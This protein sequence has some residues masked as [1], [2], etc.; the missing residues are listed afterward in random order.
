[1]CY[2][3]QSP[4]TV[5]RTMKKEYRGLKQLN[6]QYILRF[7]RKFEKT[8]SMQDTRHSNKGRPK[9]VKNEVRKVIEQ[10]SQKS[11]RKVQVV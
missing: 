7:V 10:T 11:E 4:G 1:M 6:N 5:M 9:S 2:K 3:T 8:G